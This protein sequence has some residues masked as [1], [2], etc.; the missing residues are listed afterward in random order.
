MT[1]PRSINPSVW[2]KIKKLPCAVCG[3]PYN[4]H[5]DHIVPVSVE[6]KSK[7]SNL[8]PLCRDCNYAKG[9]KLTN[10]QVAMEV[11]QRGKHHFLYAVYRWDTRFEDDYGGID[12]FRWKATRPDRVSFGM[13]IHRAFMNK[14]RSPS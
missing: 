12:F 2:H 1:K 14:L 13:E 5:C 6:G 4:I 11:A 10:D 8:Q 9:N 3:V 7:E